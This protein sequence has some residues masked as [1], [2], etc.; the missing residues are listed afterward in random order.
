MLVEGQDFNDASGWLMGQAPGNFD[1]AFLTDGG[2]FLDPIVMTADD[3]VGS[4]TVNGTRFS[5]GSHELFVNR[6]T[7]IVSLSGAIVVPTGGELRSQDLMVDDSGSLTPQGGTVTVTNQFM[8]AADGNFQGYGTISVNNDGRLTN[9]TTI[10]VTG[11]TAYAHDAI[12][13]RPRL[14]SIWTAT[15]RMANWTS[16]TATCW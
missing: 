3:S 16:A 7:T 12:P 10:R 2:E 5:T 4:L 11:R 1:D 14:H 15:R 6:T 8:L 13:V 9:N